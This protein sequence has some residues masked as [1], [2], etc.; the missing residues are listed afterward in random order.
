[1]DFLTQLEHHHPDAGI[2][3]EGD[4]FRRGDFRVLKYLIEQF[5][6]NRGFLF[7]SSP[8]D[9][10]QH[11]FR[12]ADTSLLKKVRDGFGYQLRI[13]VSHKEP[14]TSPLPLSINGEGLEERS[15]SETGVL[16]LLSH[17]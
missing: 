2:L 4:L 3:T 13:D 6:G 17:H 1:M 9:C 7:V 15:L 14:S 11:I 5:A 12:Q 16:I 8:L 10:R